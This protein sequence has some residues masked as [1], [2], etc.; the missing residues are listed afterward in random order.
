MNLKYKALADVVK[1]VGLLICLLIVVT[2]NGQSPDAVKRLLQEDFMQGVSFALAVRDVD[3]DTFL[4]AFDEKRRLTP[5]SVMKTVTT[6]TA[7]ELLG[8]DFCFS[9]VISYKGIIRNDTLFGDLYI[10]GGGDPTIGS[11]YLLTEKK[12]IPQTD[13]IEEWIVAVRTEG[14]RTITGSVLADER[15]QDRGVSPKWLLEDVGNYY[16]AGCYGLNVFDN[17]YTLYL[18]TGEAGEHPTLKYCLPELSSICFH[19]ALQTIATDDGNTPVAYITGLPLSN[20][21]YLSGTV[22]CR[23]MDYPLHGDIPDPPLFLAGLFTERLCDAGIDVALTAGCLR[24]SLADTAIPPFSGRALFTVTSPPLGRIIRITNEYSHNL[25]A[26]ALL[27][28][29]GKPPGS[30][31]RG[32]E[33]LTDCWTKRGLDVIPLVMYDGSGLATADK[34]SAQFVVSLLVYMAHSENAEIYLNSFPLAG[35]EGTVKNFLKGTHLEGIVRLKSGSMMAVRCYAGYVFYEERRYAL[36]LLVN[37]YTCPSATII[38][39]FEQLILEL[40]PATNKQFVKH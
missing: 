40:F 3:T 10:T 9:T 11:Q 13:F 4:Y 19:N 26:D 2:A 36:A 28:V 22:P 20:E 7:L 30:Y 37:N 25:Y 32:I 12:K 27:K 29:L 33:V 34:L 14:I 6:A 5:A 8:P 31:E 16:G 23:R 1:V 17:A 35:K 39:A 24:S 15:G 21:R 18:E 38:R